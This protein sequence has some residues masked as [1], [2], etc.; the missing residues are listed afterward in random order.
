V[1]QWLLTTDGFSSATPLRPQT[2]ALASDRLVTDRQTVVDMLPAS[3]DMITTEGHLTSSE[4]DIITGVLEN[5]N[6]QSR[7]KAV[8]CLI[9]A[10]KQKG[11]CWRCGF[12]RYVRLRNVA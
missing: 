1:C 10:N 7:A 3:Q 11:N 5:E 6:M 12:V 4:K 2:S 9:L 8:F